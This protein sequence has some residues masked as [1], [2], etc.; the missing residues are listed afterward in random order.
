MRI[1]YQCWHS[2]YAWL[3]SP[4]WPSRCLMSQALVALKDCCGSDF[5]PVIAL[6]RVV[7]RLSLLVSAWQWFLLVW[8]LLVWFLFSS[9]VTSACLCVCLLCFSSFLTCTRL[10]CRC[11][12]VRM[13]LVLNPD[14]HGGH[15][16]ISVSFKGWPREDMHGQVLLDPSRASSEQQYIFGLSVR[17]ICT[18]LFV[19]MSQLQEIGSSIMGIWERYRS[20][21]GPLQD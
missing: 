2:W 8:F 20:L 14:W 3:C 9:P 19:E 6:P 7:L 1:Q 18:N 21:Q 5:I 10:C 12:K 15:C 16:A 11:L 4:C 13:L 17:D